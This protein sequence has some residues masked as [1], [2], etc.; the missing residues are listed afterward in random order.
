MPEDE[1]FS[2]TD[3]DF[4]LQLTFSKPPIVEWWYSIKKE[5]PQRPEKATK[6]LF[7]L[8]TT[9]LNGAGF[10]SCTSPKQRNTRAKA[11]ADTEPSCAH[12][13]P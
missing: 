2:A 7:S 9:Y 1:K 5:Y 10:S 8:S 6:V 3:S 12:L 11:E 4:T 13:T